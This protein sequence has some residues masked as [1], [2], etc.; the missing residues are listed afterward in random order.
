[1]RE[2]KSSQVKENEDSHVTGGRGRVWILGSCQ[3][4]FEM[5]FEGC[6]DDV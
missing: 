5:K 1:M 2:A 4:K 6:W 3:V